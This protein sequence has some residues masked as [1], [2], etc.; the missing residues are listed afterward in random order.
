MPNINLKEILDQFKGE[1][2]EGIELLKQ[3]IQMFDKQGITGAE[4]KTQAKF[5]QS[6][7]SRGLAGSTVAPAVSAGISREFEDIRVGR[8]TEAMNNLANFFASPGTIAHTATGGFGAQTQLEQQR[9]EQ[10]QASFPSIIS[11]NQQGLGYQP[12]TNFGSRPSFNSGPGGGSF[13]RGDV[14]GSAVD[15]GGAWGQTAFDVSQQGAGGSRQT[16]AGMYTTKD[17]K[18]ESPYTKAEIDAINDWVASEQDS[19]FQPAP[20]PSAGVSPGV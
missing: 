7:A 10:Q 14:S 16:I 13:R 20:G 8:L 3:V 12:P 1:H 4:K 18:F 9:F 6:A 19:G 2:G 17:V 5:A 11:G 15:S